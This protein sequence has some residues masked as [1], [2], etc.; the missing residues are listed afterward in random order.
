MNP[1]DRLQL[2]FELPTLTYAREIARYAW[3]V[4]WRNLGML[5]FV[6]AVTVLPFEYL[7]SYL[8][9]PFSIEHETLAVKA[10]YVGSMLLVGIMGTLMI[11]VTTHNLIGWMRTGENPPLRE[12]FNFGIDLWPRT[13]WI[14]T[15]AGLGVAGAGLLLVVPGILL[16]YSWLFAEV[17]VAVENLTDV[18][19][20]L[21]RSSE[22]T[23]GYRMD[24]CVAMF[25]AGIP[26]A[27]L[28]WGTDYL[29]RTFPHWAVDASLSTVT[30]IANQYFV[31]LV[32]VCYLDRRRHEEAAIAFHAGA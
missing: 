3:V 14:R 16:W 27:V 26:F 2:D 23:K 10:V 29:N 17:I 22:L 11:P 5:A 12:S 20:I 4:Y 24:M 15:V 13:V 7:T 9:A 8:W 32:L 30:A 28:G 1:F 21:R 18:R 25:L 6:T 19:D 31:C